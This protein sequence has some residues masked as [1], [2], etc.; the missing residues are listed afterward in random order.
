MS[1]QSS[2]QAD[3]GSFWTGFSVGMLA[4]AVSYFL[5]ATDRGEKVRHELKEEWHTAQKKV[6]GEAGQAAVVS[7]RAMVREVV[8]QVAAKLELNLEKKKTESAKPAAKKK[9]ETVKTGNKFKGVWY[10]SAN[11]NS[12]TPS[13][14]SQLGSWLRTF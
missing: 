7:I 4:G 14:Y 11:R 9:K 5:F 12:A 3:H 10:N 13:P 2:S 6:V 1:D 8:D